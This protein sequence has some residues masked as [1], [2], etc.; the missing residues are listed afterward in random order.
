MKT[1]MR[2]SG[3]PQAQQSASSSFEICLRIVSDT[4][5]DSTRHH[6]VAQVGLCLIVT[7]AQ[8]Y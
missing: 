2:L 1:C 8:P 3:A 7:L 4:C 6:L 5:S